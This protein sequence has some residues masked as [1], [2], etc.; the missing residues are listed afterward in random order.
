MFHCQIGHDPTQLI[1]C[2]LASVG[3]GRGR[4][5]DHVLYLAKTVILPLALACFFRSY[6]L[7]WSHVWKEPGYPGY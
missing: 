3:R 4:G 6:W 5:P 7:P 1:S 2:T